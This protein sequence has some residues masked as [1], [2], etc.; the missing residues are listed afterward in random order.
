LHR[1]AV[2]CCLR[3]DGERDGTRARTTGCNRKRR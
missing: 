2:S 1:E 3:A